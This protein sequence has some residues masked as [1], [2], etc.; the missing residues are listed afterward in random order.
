MSRVEY[1][2]PLTDDEMDTLRGNVLAYKAL[3]GD[4]VDWNLCAIPPS[5]P[6]RGARRPKSTLALTRT[7][8]AKP[9]PAPA[10]A[11]RREALEFYSRKYATKGEFNNQAFAGLTAFLKKHP[12][13]TSN[14]PLSALQ[15]SPE[16]DS[17]STTWDCAHVPY[18]I[19]SAKSALRGSRALP[20]ANKSAKR[21]C[22]RGSRRPPRCLPCVWIAA[23]LTNI[24]QSKPCTAVYESR[25]SPKAREV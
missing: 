8:S 16:Q 5:I 18:S 24:Y 3:Y 11:R 1:A 22:G 13:E 23:I 9:R 2:P 19:R 15:V 17:G 12:L 21:M 6:R 25:K 7:P 10:T 14:T 4:P 20:S